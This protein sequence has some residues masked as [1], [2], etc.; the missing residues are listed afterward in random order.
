LHYATHRSTYP[1]WRRP[2][3]YLDEAV[4]AGMSLFALTPKAALAEGLSRLR[5]DLATGLWHRRHAE[6]LRQSELDLGYRL[7]IAKL[8]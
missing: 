5:S 6:L 1:Y 2:H 3:V 8:D 7:V 4:Q